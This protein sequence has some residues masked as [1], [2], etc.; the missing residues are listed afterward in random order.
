MFKTLPFEMPPI[1]SYPSHAFPLSVLSTTNEYL[2]W[3]YSNYIQVYYDPDKI[4][5]DFYMVDA[6][7]DLYCPFLSIKQVPRDL[8]NKCS[9]KGICN[10]LID[11]INLGYY[12]FIFLDEYY[13]RSSMAYNKVHFDHMILIYGYNREK[14][15]FNVSGFFKNW[16]YHTSTASFNEIKMAYYNLQKPQ[17][18]NQELRLL[19]LNS[20]I[21]KYVFDIRRIKNYLNDYLNS[22]NNYDHNSV[23][24]DPVP[25][26]RIYG[27]KTIEGLTNYIDFLK[28]YGQD[29][30]EISIKT[31]H[32]LYD[33][34]KLM[35]KRIQYLI[36]QGFLKNGKYIYNKYLK[37]THIACKIRNVMIKYDI[38]RDSR[39]LERID[40]Y[41]KKLYLLEK[42]SLGELLNC[43]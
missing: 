41:L 29:N 14:K 28:Q 3:L 13:I 23:Y 12:I 36:D 4:L 30:I 15:Y 38:I 17:A 32:V 22:T 35:L 20:E 39:I 24:Y 7:N 2:P 18:W 19:R 31:F 5:F 21:P 37:C 27:L 1:T 25:V 11:C 42:Q 26:N 34:K 16:K 33:H 6:L 43:L 9:P 40:E 8:V 10:F